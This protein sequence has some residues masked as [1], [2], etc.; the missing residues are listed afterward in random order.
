MVV[1]KPYIQWK[2]TDEAN[3]ADIDPTY[4]WGTIIESDKGPID[5][6][7]FITSASQA[8]RIFNYNLDPFFLNGGRYAVVVR[9]YGVSET[10][11][12]PSTSKFDF[13]LDEEFKYAY[14]DYEYY[15]DG[16]ET[17]KAT[18][19][20]LE[21]TVS[22]LHP[23]LAKSTDDP[24]DI[25]TLNVTFSQGRWRE[26]TANG[27]ILYY[28]E[29][30]VG[31]N[32]T[33]PEAVYVVDEDKYYAK[34][35]CSRNVDNTKWVPNTPSGTEA[36]PSALA[37]VYTK[38]FNES[39]VEKTLTVKEFIAEIGD[40]VIHVESNYPGD[41]EI[42][43]TVAPDLRGGYRVSIKESNDY[44]IMLSGA[45]SLKYISTRINERAQN[46]I[47]NLT[48]KGESIE[49]VLSGTVIPAPQDASENN[50]PL[51][52]ANGVS[53]L[54]EYV[55]YLDSLEKKPPVGSVFAYVKPDGQ[56][57]SFAFKLA[58]TTTYMADGSNG[59]W[60]KEL[61]RIPDKYAVAAHEEA[62]GHLANV[63]LSGIFCM[64][65]EDKIQKLYTDHVSTTEPAGMN[66]TEVCKWRELI[67]GANNKDRVPD[68]QLGR[69]FNIYDKA[70]AFDNEYIIYLAQGLVDTGYTPEA[71]CSLVV[72][73]DDNPVLDNNGNKQYEPFDVELPNQLLPYQAVQY[74]AGLR[75]GLF[76][77]DSIFGG[78][79]KKRIRGVG[80]LSIAPLI[81]GENKVFWQPDVYKELNEYGCLTFTEE[82]G[83]ISLTDGVT[84]RQSPLEQDEEGVVS[85]KKYA[86]HAVHE[87]LQ[88]YIGRNITGDL[89]TGMEVEVR[90][91]LNNMYTIDKTLIDLPEE[92]LPAFDVEIIM[93]PKS[94]A[95]QILSKVY[96]Y[97]KI[98]PVHALRQI[99]VEL[100]VQ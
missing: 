7:V 77:G 64:Y 12:R 35:D 22:T 76:Y 59:P 32:I 11:F 17:P 38:A 21:N 4:L 56:L 61:F 40:P 90:N 91:V 79:A 85:I 10:G 83:Q 97:L 20:V 58:E 69:T 72:D 19:K 66:S 34:D 81:K 47:S 60:D 3:L 75:S 80:K 6:P 82:Y 8:K 73:E 52:D 29:K 9:A 23:K 26:C 94:D 24:D 16:D 63:K 78:E 46:I 86:Q 100:T 87:T 14:I 70:I 65:G 27:D 67:V 37:E 36:A 74:V 49:R 2:I 42:P 41:F 43:V 71:N 51:E 50:I 5:T 62:L 48:I 30:K 33:Y 44:T 15:H 55:T 96:V 13:T 25:E 89:Q 68:D 31:D 39:E 28:Y 88:K 93:A 45:T 1:N 84:T 92:G 99:E 18:V 95:N 98:T 54:S 53:N 57:S